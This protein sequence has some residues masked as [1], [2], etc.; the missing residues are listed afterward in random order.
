MGGV[1]RFGVS[2]VLVCETV[3]TDL[4]I[5]VVALL[6][7]CVADLFWWHVGIVVVL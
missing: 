6:V 2:G 4:T 5:L 3:A 1:S 7:C